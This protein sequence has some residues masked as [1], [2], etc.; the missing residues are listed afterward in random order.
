METEAKRRKACDKMGV[1]HNQAP[2]SLEKSG[3]CGIRASSA[4]RNSAM[5]AEARSLTLALLS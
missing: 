5:R 1:S 2:G 3:Y 4:E